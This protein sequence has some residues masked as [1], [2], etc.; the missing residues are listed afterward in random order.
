MKNTGLGEEIRKGERSKINPGDDLK[1][2]EI[3]HLK[4]RDK[5]TKGGECIVCFESS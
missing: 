1:N 4:A 2:V 5:A 3:F